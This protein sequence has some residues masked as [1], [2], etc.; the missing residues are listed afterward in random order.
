MTF[1]TEP[2][3][4]DEPITWREFDEVMENIL[5]LNEH[6]ELSLETARL[7]ACLRRICALDA[8][9]D[10]IDHVNFLNG[11]VRVGGTNFIIP[12]EYRQAF[13]DALIAYLKCKNLH[14]LADRVL[15]NVA[16]GHLSSP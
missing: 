9:V 8:T 2:I 3:T 7:E 14:A 1:S 10:Q 12:D 11:V 5:G 6:S 15:S 4:R 16:I 13:A